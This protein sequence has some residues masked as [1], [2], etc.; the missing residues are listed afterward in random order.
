MEFGSSVHT[1]AIGAVPPPAPAAAK[2][3]VG[4]FGKLKE[5]KDRV[6]SS[7]ATL[8]K[9]APSDQPQT[10]LDKLQTAKR[11]MTQVPSFGSIL[12][13]CYC[14]SSILVRV[15]LPSFVCPQIVHF[16]QAAVVRVRK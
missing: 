16:E 9:T 5:T 2:P 6:T 1:G 12:K 14:G 8:A 7:L 10:L 3:R 13:T 15:V 11:R 4:L